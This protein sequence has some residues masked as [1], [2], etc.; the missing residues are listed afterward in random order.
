VTRATIDEYALALA[1][2]AA[3]RSEDPHRQVGACLIRQDR[4]VAGLGY[5][6]APP[7][8]EIDWADREDRRLWVIHAEANALRY[9]R[10]GEAVLLAVTSLPCP[11]CMMSAASYGVRR[12]VYRDELDPKVYDRDLI[13][14]IARACGVEVVKA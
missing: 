13:L 7:S 3:T 11:A 14:R 6:G 1:T 2:T 10:P 4:T 5:N 8:V 12:V 9:V